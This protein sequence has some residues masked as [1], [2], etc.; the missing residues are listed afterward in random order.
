[1]CLL[2][3]GSCLCPEVGAAVYI[4][5]AEDVLTPQSVQ[6]TCPS[7]VQFKAQLSLNNQGETYIVCEIDGMLLH[8]LIA[9]YQA[10]PYFAQDYIK[11]PDLQQHMDISVAWLC[12][13]EQGMTT[14]P[15]LLER[16]VTI[17]VWVGLDHLLTGYSYGT[18]CVTTY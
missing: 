3:P 17:G 4:S 14:N 2:I 12:A 9:A 6:E 7:Q 5:L 11:T 16:A 10:V 15:D 18:R 1:M 8:S 13:L